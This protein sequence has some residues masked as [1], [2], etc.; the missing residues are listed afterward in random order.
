MVCG[1]NE[2]CKTENG[3]PK[4][5]KKSTGIGEFSLFLLLSGIKYS[6]HCEHED[7]KGV[8]EI[9]MKRMMKLRLL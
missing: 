7:V 4:C 9:C 5:V 3:A 2:Y 6:T 1:E 8:I